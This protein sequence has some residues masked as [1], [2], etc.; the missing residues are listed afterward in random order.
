MIPVRHLVFHCRSGAVKPK[1]DGW[2][3]WHDAISFCSTR[4][5]SSPILE[6]KV[7][8]S[9]ARPRRPRSACRSKTWSQSRLARHTRGPWP[10]RWR[11]DFGAGC[12][13]RSPSWWPPILACLTRAF[14]TGTASP[15]E[16]PG[17]SVMRMQLLTNRVSIF[18]SGP[19]QW[20]ASVSAPIDLLILLHHPSSLFLLPSHQSRSC[21][22]PATHTFFTSSYI[23]SIPGS[24]PD[25]VL[26]SATS[27]A[28]VLEHIPVIP[29]AN[30][31]LLSHNSTPPSHN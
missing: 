11:P 19:S 31:V 24:I 30:R 16:C 26:N 3:A 14:T 12:E 20:L 7:M 8:H 25:I 10:A 4:I 27:L 22:L 21:S 28:A 17:F 9:P 1:E 5:E 23:S 18:V 13:E 29:L 6:R 15:L 2:K